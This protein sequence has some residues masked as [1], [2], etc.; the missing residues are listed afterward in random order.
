MYAAAAV[1]PQQQIHKR[2]KTCT[3]LLRFE[4]EPPKST[5]NII[6]IKL[7]AQLMIFRSFVRLLHWGRKRKE[8][9]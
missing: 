5:C 3:S 4:P 8:K 2:Q 6:I 1:R 7:E 9:K